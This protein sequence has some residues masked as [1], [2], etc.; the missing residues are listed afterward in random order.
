MLNAAAQK[1]IYVPNDLQ[2]M[3]LLCDSSTWSYARMTCTDN[4]AIMWQKGFGYD[5]SC[6]PSL[7]GKPMKV[8]IDNLK[9]KLESYYA[10]FR[11]SLQFT[12]KG[13]KAE[14]YRMMVMLNL[15]AGNYR[16]AALCYYNYISKRNGQN[17]SYPVS[18]N[19]I[20]WQDDKFTFTRDGYSSYTFSMEDFTSTG[21]LITM[22]PGDSIPSE[23]NYSELQD[24]FSCNANNQYNNK[25]V[26]S[27]GLKD[28]SASQKY[29]HLD[30]AKEI[31][32]APAELDGLKSGDLRLS[33][34]YSQGHM[35]GGGSSIDR[36]QEVWTNQKFTTR[37][38]HINRRTL[39]YL[40]MAEAL[41]RAGFPRFAFAI[42]KTGVN[43]EVIENEVMPY[44]PGEEGFLSQFDFPNSLYVL[45]SKAD[46]TSENTIGIHARGCGWT[47]Y[48]N[49]YIFPDNEGL[50]GVERINYQIEAVED[51]IINE[52]ALETSFEGY[53]FY[54]L[55]RVALRRGDATYLAD[56]VYGRR[57]SQ[58]VGEMK[59][60]IKCDLNNPSNW[61]LNWNGKIGINIE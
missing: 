51:L 30:N 12:R 13:S 16:D 42:L 54:D 60:L 33:A 53:R 39:V 20:N 56:R 31:Q 49:Y 45:R 58:K 46:L 8:D 48:D 18:T 35:F 52:N 34:V 57:G 55:M 38:V 1:T 19:S 3:N 15:W 4:F 10:F 26:P 22:I 23:G 7:E 11:D 29:C 44:Y 50:S 32:Y 2:K 40:R 27:Q 25:V 59:S 28:L 47:E 41:N 37:N 5:L 6:P 17:S 43:N 9:E 21:E 36:N 24:I 61:Y 14:K